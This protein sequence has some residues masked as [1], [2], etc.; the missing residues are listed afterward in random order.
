MFPVSADALAWLIQE[1]SLPSIEDDEDGGLRSLDGTLPEGASELSR[2]AAHL[3]GLPADDPA[4]SALIERARGGERSVLEVGAGRL[5]AFCVAP[6]RARVVFAR[7]SPDDSTAE[8]AA[9]V[10]HEVANALTAITGW[11]RMAASGGPLPERSRHAL[12]VVQRSARDALDSARELLGLMRDAAR[13]TIAPGAADPIA[14]AEGVS[15]VLETLG[16]EL[17]D[18]G[19]HLET[20]LAASAY[21]AVPGPVLR[22]IVSNLVKNALEALPRGG[23]V[24]VS[25]RDEDG[26]VRLTVADDG[27]GMSDATLAHAFDRYF[28]TKERGTGLGLALIA[29]AVQEAGGRLETESRRGVGTRFDV[30]LPSARAPAPTQLPPHLTGTSGV[31]PKPLLVDKAVLV[32]DDDEAMRALIRTALE[33]QGA[34]VRTAA[35]IDDA[36]ALEGPFVLALVDLSLGAHRGDA[37]LA[38][39]RAA[40]RV[41]RAILITGSPDAELDPLGCPDVVLRKPFELEELTRTIDA[42]LEAPALEAKG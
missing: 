21:A 36:L 38:R 13:T 4:V 19:V 10:T 41:D 3:A 32:V 17:D 18:A 42:V 16:V 9:G 28:T 22:L 37:L 15:E 29:E 11:A 7:R 34:R 26:E 40:G 25:L 39:L 8:R 2:A 14:G 1:L 24:R 31:H 5:L 20:D 23:T 27:P 35:G 33:L 12:D 30:W 6:G